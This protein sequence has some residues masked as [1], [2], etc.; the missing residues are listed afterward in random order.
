MKFNDFLLTGNK[1]ER[2]DME[3]IYFNQDQVN[4]IAGL[5][6]HRY[7]TGNIS[8]ASLNDE[9]ISNSHARKIQC[10]NYSKF[11]YDVKTKK[12]ESKDLH[13]ELFDSAISNIK[14]M[15]GCTL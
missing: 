8:C 4:E 12:F 10:H 15:D 11:W 6:I 5:Y 14:K 3:R 2:G 9:K 13:S 7:G 1:W